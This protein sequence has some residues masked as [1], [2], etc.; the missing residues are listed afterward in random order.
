MIAALKRRHDIQVREKLAA[1]ADWTETGFI[2]TTAFGQP[3]DYQPLRERL[4]SALKTLG[5]PKYTIHSFRHATATYLLASGVQLAQVQQ[6]LGH[7]QVS[8]TANLYGHVVPGASDSIV[9]EL[10]DA[11]DTSQLDLRIN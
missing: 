3:I 5:L 10:A 6:L 2:F 11:L 1:G 8:L 7:S 4:N 9:Q